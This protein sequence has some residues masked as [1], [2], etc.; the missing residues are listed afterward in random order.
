MAKSQRI[1]NDLVERK[2]LADINEFGWDSMNALEDDGHPPWT[3]TIGLYDTWRFPELIIVGRNRATGSFAPVRP[4]AVTSGSKEKRILFRL[5]TSVATRG[6]HQ[7][8]GPNP[9]FSDS[10]QKLASSISPL[11]QKEPYYL[12]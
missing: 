1:G 3:F 4:P 8:L 6:M 10:S 9:Q 11:S 2:V 7:T 12:C 5:P